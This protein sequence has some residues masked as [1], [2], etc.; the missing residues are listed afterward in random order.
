MERMMNMKNSL[1]LML[2]LTSISSYGAPSS[3]VDCSNDVRAA[4]I[5][6]V[7]ALRPL[8]KVSIVRFHVE[9][10]TEDTMGRPTVRYS[11]T[12]I[13]K[14]GEDPIMP[15][16]GVDA[17]VRIVNGRCEILELTV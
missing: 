10:D 4:A 6:T 1:L 12:P 8:E 14:Q 9:A 7:A 15:N 11:S 2:I 13:Y 3:N 17:R 5:K 16:S